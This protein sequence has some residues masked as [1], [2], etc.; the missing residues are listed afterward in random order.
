MP[1]QLVKKTCKE[2]VIVLMINRQ[3]KK[4]VRFAI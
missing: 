4:H 2:T 3:G 1:V